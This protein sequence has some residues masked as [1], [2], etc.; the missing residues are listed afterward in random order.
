MWHYSFLAEH[1]V[2]VWCNLVTILYDTDLKKLSTF[3]FAA[4]LTSLPELGMIT[5]SLAVGCRA[6]L[7]QGLL[8]SNGRKN[9]M[10]WPKAEKSGQLGRRLNPANNRI[11]FSAQVKSI[12][13]KWF[14]K[15][16][17]LT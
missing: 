14:W 2:I 5:D 4:G 9:W 12:F 1:S 8:W 3:F 16:F 17:H 7:E 6:V 11:H 10:L 15:D 13:N